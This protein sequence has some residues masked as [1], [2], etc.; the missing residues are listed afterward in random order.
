MASA[1]ATANPIS[2]TNARRLHYQAQTSN[3]SLS[4]NQS[5]S[6]IDQAN[7]NDAFSSPS[8]TVTPLVTI[9]YSNASLLQGR[10]S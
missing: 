6:N 4:L 8:V 3:T 2:S 5:F 7:L 9:V 1:T 10:L